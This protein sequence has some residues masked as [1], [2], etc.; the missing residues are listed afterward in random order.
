MMFAAASGLL[1]LAA[2]LFFS[3]FLALLLLQLDTA[4]LQWNTYLR[5]INTIDLPQVQPYAGKIKAGGIIG[6]GLPLLGYVGLLFLLFK[7]ARRSAHGDARFATRADLAKAGLL[8]DTP[9]GIVLGKFGN[10]LIRL[11]GQQH[12]ILTAPTRSGKTV[13][14]AIPVLLTFEDSIVALDI[15]GELVATTSGWRQ[16][17]GHQVCVWAPFTEDRITHRFNPFMCVSR[18]PDLRINQL[19]SI[20]AILYPDDPNK[21][22]FWINQSRSAFF[23]FALYMF[24][25]W[26]DLERQ[27]FPLC[28]DPNVSPLFPSFERIYRLSSGDGS[29]PKAQ[30][31]KLMAQAFVGDKTRTAF[32]NLLSQ[33]EETFSSILGSMQEPLHMF[34]N[35][36]LAAA[37][38][39]CDFDVGELRRRKMTVYVVVSPNKLGEARKI[40][41]IFFSMVLARNTSEMPGEHPAIKHQCLLLMDEFTAMGRVDIL[42]SS[43]SYTAGY[44]MRSLPIIQSLSQLDATYGAD[45]A[46]TFVTNHAASIVFAPREQRDAEEYSKMLG[47]TTVR[48]RQRSTSHGQSGNVSYTEIEERRELMKPQE[49]KAL[50]GDSQIIFYEGCPHPIKCSK[51]KYYRDKYFEERLLSKVNI[52]PLNFG[53]TSAPNQSAWPQISDLARQRLGS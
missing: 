23:A 51:I 28:G 30:L 6:F 53:K 33:A 32:A 52:P 26:D 22:P 50:G 40:L 39:A 5:Y 16:S 29:D 2:G 20:G 49:L 34:L 27:Q 14:V 17:Q 9:T 38:N 47:D 44:W 7:P 1:T 45:V 21:D 4:L 19:Q 18:D 43:I 41:N 10:D 48:R 24:E 42:A 3:G 11:G 37:T 13:G 36:I 35:P 15:K 31:R 46:R 25:N 8:K 12:V